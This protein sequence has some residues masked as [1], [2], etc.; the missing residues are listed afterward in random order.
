MLCR[1]D[2]CLRALARFRAAVGTP[3]QKTSPA[4]QTWP[5]SLRTDAGTARP[6]E[7]E[8]CCWGSFKPSHIGSWSPPKLI[9]ASYLVPAAVAHQRPG[10][11]ERT[12]H[13]AHAAT[14]EVVNGSTNAPR[15]IARQVPSRD[16]FFPMVARRLRT[17]HRAKSVNKRRDTLGEQQTPTL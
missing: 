7:A 14:T 6:S 2:W 17:K 16:V 11:D 15:S 5:S 9:D 10:C 4:R 8:T 12:Q 3:R 1:A 13:R